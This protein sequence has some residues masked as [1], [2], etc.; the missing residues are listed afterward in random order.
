MSKTNYTDEQFEKFVKAQKDWEQFK[1]SMDDLM[2]VVGG[3]SE[4]SPGVTPRTDEHDYNHTE[5]ST[6]VN[7]KLM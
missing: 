5:G 4:F 3:E 7:S 1:L 6:N 2:K